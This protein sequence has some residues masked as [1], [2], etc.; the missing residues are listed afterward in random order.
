LV[1]ADFRFGW[2]GNGHYTGNLTGEDLDGDGFLRTEEIT[3]ITESLS[4]H[5]LPALFDIGDIDIANESWTP[6][7]VSCI[8]YPNTAFMTFDN[9][10]RSCTTYNGCNAFFTSFVTSNVDVPGPSTLALLGLG[11]VGIGLSRKKRV[12]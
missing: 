11:L 12:S 4:N 3:S 10:S 6:N 8:G 5:T 7:A 2:S 1:D 9:G